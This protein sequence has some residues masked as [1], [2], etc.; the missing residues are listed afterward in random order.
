[1]PPPDNRSPLAIARTSKMVSASV[2]RCQGHH[3]VEAR[4]LLQFTGL[5]LLLVRG[6]SDCLGAAQR[7]RLVL[8]SARAI[9]G[10]HRSARCRCRLCC[11]LVEEPN[12][13]LQHYRPAPAD[14]RHRVAAFRSGD[15]QRIVAG[16]LGM[17]RCGNLRCVSAGMEVCIAGS[18]KRFLSS[19]TSGDS[20]V[21]SLVD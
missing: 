16:R 1:M 8:A 15:P 19:A 4:R 7:R 11:E 20:R 6:I 21:A 2:G 18:V 13:S 3:L 10:E 12:L 9:R 17:C 5:D 14:S